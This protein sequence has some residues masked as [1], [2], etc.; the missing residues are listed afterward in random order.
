MVDGGTD[1][2]FPFRHACRGARIHVA[3]PR[4]PCNR[5]FPIPVQ[6]VLYALTLIPFLFVL[7]TGIAGLA[8]FFASVS[9]RGEMYWVYAQALQVSMVTISTVFYPAQTIAQYLPAPVATIAEYNPLSLAAGVLRTSAFGGNPLDAGV[10]AN[11]L[12]TSLPLA[13]LGA[14]AYWTI[15]R[16]IRLNG[17][18]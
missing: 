11:L 3:D 8:A 10:L 17:K 6:G 12:A 9:R 14:L 13:V 5:L 7:S 2:S 16:N 1:Q 18:P 4:L 15:L